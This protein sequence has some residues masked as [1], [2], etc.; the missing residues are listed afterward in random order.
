MAFSVKHQNDNAHKTS[1]AYLTILILQC[2]Q[3]RSLLEMMYSV[4]RV[5]KHIMKWILPLGVL[6]FTPPSQQPTRAEPAWPHPKSKWVMIFLLSHSCTNQCISFFGDKVPFLA[7]DSGSLQKYTNYNYSLPHFVARKKYTATNVQTMPCT[8][9]TKI[10]Q[11]WSSMN[12]E[13][14]SMEARSKQMLQQHCRPRRNGPWTWVNGL[15]G[16]KKLRGILH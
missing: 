11:G 4:N 14:M 1:L 5:D 12:L 3:N 16:A 13:S 15:K 8:N 10:S 2:N 6:K 9:F 7:S